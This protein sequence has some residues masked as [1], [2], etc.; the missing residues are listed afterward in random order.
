MGVV[1]DGQWAAFCKAF[2]LSDW[3]ADESLKANNE[4]VKRRD[5]II[6]RLRELFKGMSQK[7]L[8]EKLDTTGL[9]YAPISKPE[10][11][12]EDPHLNASG[13]LVEM[14]LP[15]GGQIILPS[16]PVAIN[17][18]RPGINLSPPKVGE[19]SQSVLSDLGVSADEYA[20]M[21]EAG[22]VDGAA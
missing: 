5:E 17:G 19:H 4:R 7:D 20:E 9:P 15:T 16:L 10:D 2:E 18:E 8:M 12:F 3:E 22:L 14:E 11:L 13:G 6:P 1:S 21:V